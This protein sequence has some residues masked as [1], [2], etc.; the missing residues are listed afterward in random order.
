MVALG[1]TAVPLKSYNEKPLNEKFNGITSLF[2]INATPKS[3]KM[4]NQD[5]GVKVYRGNSHTDNS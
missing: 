5:T 2:S 3:L 4:R 1:D